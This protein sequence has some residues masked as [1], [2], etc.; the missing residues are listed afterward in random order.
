MTSPGAKTSEDSSFTIAIFL[1]SSC[2]GDG[3]AP[4]VTLVMRV[5]LS[6]GG[7]SWPALT[8]SDLGM[9]VWVYECMRTWGNRVMEYRPIW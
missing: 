4:P 9:E 2:S 5:V 1:S 3:G 8:S 7:G 6:P